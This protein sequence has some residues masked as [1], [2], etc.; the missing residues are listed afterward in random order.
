M[1]DGLLME[2]ECLVLLSLRKDMEL[3]FHA[4]IN[5]FLHSEHG[6][7][8]WPQMSQERNVAFSQHMLINSHV[9]MSSTKS[10]N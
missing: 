7:V 1:Q 3:K 5:S 9:K 6:A 4:G 2:S 8:F 10:R